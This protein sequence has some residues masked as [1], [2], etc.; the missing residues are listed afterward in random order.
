MLN[1]LLMQFIILSVKK[2]ISNSLLMNS[3]Q[4]NVV[5]NSTTLIY[6]SNCELN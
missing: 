4:N 2:L 3:H 1:N 6:L 5:K